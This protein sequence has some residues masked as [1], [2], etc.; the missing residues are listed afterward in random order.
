MTSLEAI[1]TC[2]VIWLY[3]FGVVTA[4]CSLVSAGQASSKTLAAFVSWGW[5]III[6]IGFVHAAV[7]KIKK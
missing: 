7:R 1:L 5:P 6:P 2:A 4:Y 3:L